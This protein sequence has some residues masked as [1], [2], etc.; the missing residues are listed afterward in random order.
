MVSEGPTKGIDDSF[1]A[2]EKYLV[3]T[4]VKVRQNFAEVYITMVMKVNC[5]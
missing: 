4:L 3:L 1:G 5:M 2:T